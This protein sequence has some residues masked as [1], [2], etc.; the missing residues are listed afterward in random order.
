MNPDSPLIEPSASRG[1]TQNDPFPAD[2][3]PERLQSM[4]KSVAGV[5]RVPDVMPAGIALTI[6]SAAIGKGLRIASGGGRKTMANLYS[7]VSADSGTGKTTVL[8]VLREPLDILQAHLKE[9]GRQKGL[10]RLGSL[11][12]P[13]RGR[14]FEGNEGFA[15]D[16]DVLPPRA[17]GSAKMPDPRL[18]C[19]EVTGPA[20]ARLLAQNQQI[21]LNAT[22]EAGNLLDETAKATSP[23]GQLLLKGFSGDPVEIDRITREAVVM[24]EPCISVCWLCQPHRLDK[25]LANER[26]LEDG[27]L[28]RFL[29]AH[30]NASMAQMY[31]DDDSVPVAA[32]DAYGGL[33]EELFVLYG[34]NSKDEWVVQ[35]SAEAQEVM[36]D[37]HNQCVERWNADDGPLRPCI[38][39]WSEQAWKI[40]LVL[41]AAIHGANSHQMPLDGHTAQRAFALQQWFARQQ[42]QI[43]GGAVLPAGT[44]RLARLCELLRS[45][46]NGEMTLRNLQNSHGF[47]DSE[48]R[49]LVTSAPQQLYLQK[50]QNPAGGRPSHVVGLLPPDSQPS[51]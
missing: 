10:H 35:A 50:R 39:R 7:L 23:L 2:M 11:K 33:I 1:V 17:K 29:V 37:H 8:R 36:R 24:E 5:F 15:G 43:L 46:P 40:A 6:V 28:P 51:V 25:F 38:A 41:H 18:T 9:F 45:S 19:S 21:L 16:I 3:L 30:S 48:V 13:P 49:R 44:T 20:L 42:T 27:L 32:A 34:R 26:L 12:S 14:G 47:S 4:V 31:G 22:A